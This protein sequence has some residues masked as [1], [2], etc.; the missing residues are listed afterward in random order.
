MYAREMNISKQC[1]N[2][3]VQSIA[4]V[5]LLFG[6]GLMAMT[7]WAYNLL[8]PL[9]V[10][11]LFVLVVE[12]ATA[13]VW[14]WVALKH[15]DML[16]SFFSGASGFRFLSA[17]AVLFVW[18]LVVGREGMMTFFIIFLLYYF[19]SLIHHT[20]FFTKISNYL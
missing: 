3:I 9:V 19:L 17:L 13:L 16:P 6:L 7:Q 15:Q 12:I 5:G 18:F 14:R 10:S 1:Q 4:L 2:Y 8:L 20:I 11:A